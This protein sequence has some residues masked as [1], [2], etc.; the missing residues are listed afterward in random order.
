LPGFYVPAEVQ[1]NKT[2]NE[3]AAI[4]GVLADRSHDLIQG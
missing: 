4:D 1:A 3:E 2:E